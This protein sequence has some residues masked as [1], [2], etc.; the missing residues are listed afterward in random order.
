M[1]RLSHLRW[2]WAALLLPGFLSRAVA[3]DTLNWN[4]NSDRV[5]A[6]I[7]A[8]PLMRVLEGVAKLTG[9]Q[10]YLEENTAGTVSVRFKNQPPGDALRSMLGNLNFALVPETNSRPRLYVF[11]TTQHN[12]TLLVPPRD[13]A[14]GSKKIPNELVVRLK[15]GAKI[16]DLARSLG[17]KVIGRIDGLN[18]Y[19]L[20]FPDEAA[21]DNAHGEVASNP[22][23]A[24]VDNNYS[25]DPP[26]SPVAVNATAALPQLKLSPNA[27]ASGQL[28]VGLIDTAVQPLGN[29]LDKFLLKSI[30]ITGDSA[31]PDPNVPTHGTSMFETMLNAASKVEN[32]GTASFQIVSVDV[33]GNHPTANT[34]DIASGIVQAANAGAGLINLSLGGPS[35]SP[36]LQSVIDQLTQRGIP[37]YAAAGNDGSPTELFYPA[38]YPGVVAVT[39]GTAPGQLAGYANSG[40]YVHWMGPGSSLVALGNNAWVVQGTSPA[41]AYLSGTAIGWADANKQPVVTASKNVLSTP[42]F[43]FNSGH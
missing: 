22:D 35:D 32:G 25:I 13:L 23:V 42:R 1:R 4:T 21:A 9:W 15:P 14:E 18:A 29:D 24:S 3:A 38:A 36:F 27:G 39:A 41:T 6:E 11:R 7:K 33:F 30:S 19:R 16:D 26:P 40:P 17:A 31:A 2:V 34:F 10:V 28:I 12:A 20:L 37:V 8:V 5:S 43:Q